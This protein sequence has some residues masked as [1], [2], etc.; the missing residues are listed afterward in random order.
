MNENIDC[1]DRRPWFT[2][3]LTMNNVSFLCATF[4]GLFL[5][6][7]V[8]C[9]TQIWKGYRLHNCINYTMHNNNSCF[10]NQFSMFDP[11]GA[12]KNL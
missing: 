8:T 6:A 5:N 10:R 2:S 4:V 11:C 9:T 7:I 1:K 3:M 12:P